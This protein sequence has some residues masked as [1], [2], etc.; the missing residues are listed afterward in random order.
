MR[1]VS[2][3]RSLY[4]PSGALAMYKDGECE[5]VFAMCEDGEC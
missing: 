2:E 3:R 1:I 5:K 4:L